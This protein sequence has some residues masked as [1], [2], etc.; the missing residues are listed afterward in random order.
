MIVQTTC[1]LVRMSYFDLLLASQEGFNPFGQLIQVLRFA[2]PYGL[3][4]QCTAKRKNS[5]FTSNS[6]PPA[7]PSDTTTA[8]IWSNENSNGTPPSRGKALSSP[9]NNTVIVCRGKAAAI[10]PRVAQN[11]YQGMMAAPRQ[12]ERPEVH[13][14]LTLRRGLDRTTGETG[15]RGH[16]PCTWSLTRVLPLV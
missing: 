12:R 1:I 16:I 7:R 9:S 5:A 6:S 4:P 8:R 14:V 2:F 15:S 13:L 10:R 11:H 3:N